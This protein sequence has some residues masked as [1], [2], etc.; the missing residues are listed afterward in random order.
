MFAGIE[1]APSL[2]EPGMSY[3]LVF[4]YRWEAF[5]VA[6]RVEHSVWA[7]FDTEEKWALGVLDV[8]LG[9]EWFHTGKRLRSALFL[10]TSTLLYSTPIDPAGKTGLFFDLRPAGYA[11]RLFGERWVLRL[12][13]LHVA[14]EAPVLGKIPLLKVQY[15]A[16]LALEVQL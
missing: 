16:T 9:G 4:A 10:G 6:A 12:D 8:A 7:S 13:P 15:R 11:W 1:G 14:V 5:G 3:G 2:D